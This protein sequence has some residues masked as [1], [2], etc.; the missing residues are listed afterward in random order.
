MR[1]LIDTQVFIW[2]INEDKRLGTKTRRLLSDTSNQV[3][4][5]YFSFFE[6]TIKAS[7][8]KLTYDNSVIDDLPGMDIK[9]VMPDEDVLQNYNIFNSD[10]KDPFDNAL[11]AV[12]INERHTFVTADPK[13]LAISKSNLALQDATK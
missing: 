11:V 2:L 6:M 1:L 9:L 13:I 10:N 5:S 8:G 3:H 12:A 7:I 4:I